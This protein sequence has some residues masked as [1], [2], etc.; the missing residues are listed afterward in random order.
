MIAMTR[1]LRHS[2]C[3]QVIVALSLKQFSSSVFATSSA[4]CSAFLGYN[5]SCH[6]ELRTILVNSFTSGQASCLVIGQDMLLSWLRNVHPTVSTRTASKL[7]DRQASIP[8]LP[9][10]HFPGIAIADTSCMT[11]AMNTSTVLSKVSRVSCVF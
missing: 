5:S 6:W 11:T 2:E 1:R 3:K 8:Y 9:W 10:S 7:W 4:D